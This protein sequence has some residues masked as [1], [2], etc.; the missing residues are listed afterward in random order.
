MIEKETST[1]KSLIHADT[2]KGNFR[3][4]SRPEMYTW[5]GPGVLITLKGTKNADLGKGGQTH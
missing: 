4:P 2:S 5:R 3:L 1:P